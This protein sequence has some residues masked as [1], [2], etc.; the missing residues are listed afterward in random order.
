MDGVLADLTEVAPTPTRRLRA[1]DAL[2]DAWRRLRERAAFAVVAI[3][4]IVTLGAVAAVA[5]AWAWWNGALAHTIDGARLLGSPNVATLAELLR[6]SPFGLRTIAA[7]ALAGAAWMLLLNPLLAGGLLA[8]LDDPARPRRGRVARFAADGASLY[9]P[10]LRIG[11]IVWPGAA[12]VITVAAF[13]AALPFISTAMPV[14]SLLASGLVGAA[15]VLCT[16]IVVDLARA[17]VVHTGNRRAAAA[18]AGAFG[19]SARHVTRLVPIALAYAIL[20]GLA[21][22]V[23]LAARGWLAGESWPSI[24]AALV[25]QQAHALART[26]LRAALMSTALVLVEVDVEA[27]RQAAAA[28]AGM[29]EPPPDAYVGPDRDPAGPDGLQRI[30]ESSSRDSSSH[31]PS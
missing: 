11:L 4:L 18:V 8:A 12:I 2:R 22:L 29:G 23:L 15:G 9:G 3:W 13:L 7:A 30:G 5:P 17:S 24:V 26:W 28:A 25:V 19:S 27:R 16:T 1:R 10:M 20:F 31:G 21:W 6:D 14:L